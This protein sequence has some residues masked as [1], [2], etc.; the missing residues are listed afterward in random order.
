MQ[1]NMVPIIVLKNFL[2]GLVGNQNQG[3]LECIF[4]TPNDKTTNI[5][6]NKCFKHQPK[7]LMNRQITLQATIST[8]VIGFR[9][10]LKLGVISLGDNQA[11]QNQLQ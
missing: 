3:F 7:T 9:K 8:A 4:W 2:W 10:W 11:Q 6:I 1:F 5:P